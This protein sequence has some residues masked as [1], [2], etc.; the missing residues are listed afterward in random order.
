MSGSVS[1][2][3]LEAETGVDATGTGQRSADVPVE[4]HAGAAVPV[5]AAASAAD[6]VRRLAVSIGRPLQ[7]ASVVLDVDP[8]PPGCRRD[9][10]EA[11]VQTVG[12]RVRAF[13]TGATFDEALIELEVL[14]RHRLDHA[15]ERLRQSTG[16]A[17]AGR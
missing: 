11:T 3:R 2:E 16:R 15:R 17:S 9:L 4:V 5:P 1:G 10:V 7:Y 6:L 14:L 13:A 8:E 12:L